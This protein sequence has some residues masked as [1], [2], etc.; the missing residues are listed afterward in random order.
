MDTNA[1]F[2]LAAGRLADA[3]KK[4]ENSDILE[5]FLAYDARKERGW[6]GFDITLPP[7]YVKLFKAQGFPIPISCLNAEQ[8]ARWDKINEMCDIQDA[9]SARTMIWLIAQGMLGRMDVYD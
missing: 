9:A 6:E 3:L 1:Q 8:S 5:Q 4:P 2:R 7:E